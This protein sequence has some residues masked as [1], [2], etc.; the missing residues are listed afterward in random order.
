[1]NGSN[2][3]SLAIIAPIGEYPDVRPFAQVMMSG[4]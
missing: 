1:L 2:S 4:T 3:R